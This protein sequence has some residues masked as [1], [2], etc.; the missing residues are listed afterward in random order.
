MRLKDVGGEEYLGVDVRDVEK[1]QTWR[2]EIDA[3]DSKW[4]ST[5]TRKPLFKVGFHPYQSAVV[6]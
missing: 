4:T 5:A 1:K 3:N 2:A 6:R